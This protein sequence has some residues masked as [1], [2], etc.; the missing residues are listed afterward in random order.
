M[1]RFFFSQTFRRRASIL[2]ILALAISS[3]FFMSPANAAEVLYFS[4]GDG[5][6]FIQYSTRLDLTRD[7]YSMNIGGGIRPYSFSMTKPIVTITPFYPGA[8]VAFKVI[9][10]SVGTTILTIK[11]TKGNSINR[12]LVVYDPG[13]QPLSLG[14]LPNATNPVAVGQG[15][16]FG[17][18]GGKAPYK[19]VSANPGIA[20]VEPSGVIYA[21]WGVASG[22]TQI[23]VTDAAGA[24]IQG[25]VY[26]GMIKSLVISA[27]STLLPAGKGELTISSGNPPYTVTTSSNLNATLKGNDSYG[28]TIYT[29]TAKSAGAGTVTVKDSKGLTASRAVTVKEWISLSFPQLTG[30]L[31]TID[32]GQTTKLVVT[33]GTAPYTVTADKPT[34]VTIQQQ[35]SGQ[36]TVTGCQAGVVSI[37]AKDGS[38]ATRSLSLTVRAL[39]TL[40]LAAPDTLLIGTTGNLTLVGGASP[41]NV[42]ISG[43]QVV[44]TKVADK[45]YTLTP[46]LPGKTAI[47]VK[48]S[49]GTMVQKNITVTA[50]VLKLEGSTSPLEVGS[51]RPFDIKGGVGPYTLTLTNANAKAVLYTT[52]TAYTRYNISGVTPGMVDLIVKDS[53]GATATAKLTIQAQQPAKA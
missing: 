41:F 44:L 17:V 12:E 31:R 25:T 49:R 47:T 9:P 45:K 46:K 20:R 3:L 21:V 33:G 37:T 1:I 35:G 43:N 42:S 38:G 15:R 2:T 30:D 28:R 14:A 52:T 11:D 51:T 27:D 39:P 40:T 18:L 26:V 53:Q 4:A 16:G 24:K 29:L 6:S 48:D 36:Y 50:Q 22:M 5:K 32:V 10:K 34:A 19:V 13:A 8:Q 23:T 7:F